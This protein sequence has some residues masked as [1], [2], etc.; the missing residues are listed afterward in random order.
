MRDSPSRPTE[1]DLRAYRGRVAAGGAP[2]GDGLV[3]RLFEPGAGRDRG[4]IIQA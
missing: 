2:G 4:Y 3:R 1:G